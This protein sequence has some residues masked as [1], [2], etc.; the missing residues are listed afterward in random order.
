MF[1]AGYA[2]QMMVRCMNRESGGNPRAINWRDSH[3]T[4]EGTFK[5]SFGLLQIGA[6]HAQHSRGVA[7]RLTG[8]NPYRLLD[9]LINVKA[10]KLLYDAGRRQG[11]SGFGPWNWRC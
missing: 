6:L 10:A 9:P 1:G 2:G 8:G 3:P 4:S 7:Y 11:Q 5:G